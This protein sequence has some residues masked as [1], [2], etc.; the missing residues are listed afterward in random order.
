MKLGD[1]EVKNVKEIVE[2]EITGVGDRNFVLISGPNGSGKTTILDAVKFALEGK[3]EIDEQPLR[4]D[5]EENGEIFLNVVDDDGDVVWTIKRWFTDND[6]AYLKV[7]DPE[8]NA[9]EGGDQSALDRLLDGVAFDPLR[10]VRMD[11]DEKFETVAR[12]M[13][14]EEDLEGIDEE[15]EENYEERRVVGRTVDKLEKKLDD[16]EIEEDLPEETVDKET[17]AEEHLDK[18]NEDM[19]ED[20]ETTREDIRQS[21]EKGQQLGDEIEDVEE[22]IKE[23]QEYRD[24]LKDQQQSAREDFSDAIEEPLSDFN[25]RIKENRKL[26]SKLEEL[27]EAR[28]E[29][30]QLDHTVNSLRQKRQS[31]IREAGTP[32]EGLVLT[33][34]GVQVDAEECDLTRQESGR[35]P[36]HQIEK[37]AQIKIAMSV[38]MAQNPE[39]E[40]MRVQDGSLLDPENTELVRELAQDNDYQVWFER[41]ESDDDQAIVLQEGR[42]VEGDQ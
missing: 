1:V 17:F 15:I 18:I 20:P 34:D 9:P 23:L 14:I 24:S 40:V 30:T 41:I 37:S 6:H 13:G 39:L 28:E 31:T 2:A 19:V 27:E 12:I 16:V 42:I 7:E 22:K 5:A 38:G 33:E 11:D 25:A 3:G 8:G 4:E 10:F 26:K 21:Y 36:F 29:H 32:V 35:V